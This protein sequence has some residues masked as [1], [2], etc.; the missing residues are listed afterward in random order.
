MLNPK[1]LLKYFG[2]F[3]IAFIVFQL[4][5]SSSFV[6]S[7]LAS[8]NATIFGNTSQAFLSEI[9]LN[10]KSVTDAGEIN[11]SFYSQAH[12]DQLIKKIQKTGKAGNASVP[13]YEYAFNPK[14]HI[15]TALAFLIA[16]FLATPLAWKR[17]CLLAGL[18]VI[19]FYLFSSFRVSSRFKYEISKLNIGLY[20]YDPNS[21]FNLH[22]LNNLLNSLGLIFIV[23][24]LIW[25]LLVFNK[26]NITQMKSFLS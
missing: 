26:R 4:L 21:F 7:G 2:I 1:L 23:I 8:L 5:V 9:K 17:R 24:I 15:N 14:Y 12:A 3:W 11:F 16:L 22:K 19:G 20:E 13:K 6:S 18:G 25:V 10:A